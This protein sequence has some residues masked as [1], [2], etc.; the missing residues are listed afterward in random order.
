MEMFSRACV[1]V[2][3]LHIIWI[4]LV[5]HIQISLQAFIDNIG[6]KWVK[7]LVSLLV[8]H[9]SIKKANNR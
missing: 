9:T 2:C 8:V 4:F 6:R 7:V 5:L 1:C 3:E